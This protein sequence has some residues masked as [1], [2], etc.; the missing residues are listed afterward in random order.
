MNYKLSCYY[1]INTGKGAYSLEKSGREIGSRVIRVGTNSKQEGILSL[2]IN[3]IGM[4][5]IN[6]SHEDRLMIELQNASLCR[7]LNGEQ[8]NLVSNL[9]YDFQMSFDE[10]DCKYLF[11]YNPKPY[12]MNICKNKSN[13]IEGKSISELFK[14]I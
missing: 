6:I 10:V 2:L 13:T 9:L 12:A 1:D 8:S 3:S 4:L 7:E 14:D 11:V 5:K